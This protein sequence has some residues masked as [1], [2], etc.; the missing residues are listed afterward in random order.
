[1]PHCL[2]SE[3][4]LSRP[5]QPDELLDSRMLYHFRNRNY[6]P[7]LGRR[8]RQ[9]PFGY[10]DGMSLFEY[11]R[12]SPETL[13]DP[14]G[15]EVS[16]G[17]YPDR[18][19]NAPPYAGHTSFVPDLRLI[20]YMVVN[21]EYKQNPRDPADNGYNIVVTAPGAFVKIVLDKR[22]SFVDRSLPAGLRS[23]VFVHESYHF[24]IAEIAAAAATR[25]IQKLRVERFYRCDKDDLK[26]VSAHAEKEFSAQAVKIMQKHMKKQAPIQQAYDDATNHGRN[27]AAQQAWQL[28]IDLWAFMGALP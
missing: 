26:L 13:T 9:D 8:R 11:V 15:T 18:P 21:C 25:E 6:S 16:E 17:D 2:H 5:Q 19:R 4:L 28:M 14:L 22:G 12:S 3:K 23:L 7:S 10:V 27:G 1:M 24:K 20:D